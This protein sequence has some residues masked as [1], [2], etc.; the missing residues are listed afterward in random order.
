M[1]ANHDKRKSNR[2]LY[3]HTLLQLYLYPHCDN[4]NSP[5]PPPPQVQMRSFVR[6]HSKSQ[7]IAF[8][9]GH[10]HQHCSLLSLALQHSTL[11]CSLLS[12][13]LQHSTLLCSLCLLALLARFIHR[14]AHSLH[15][16]LTRCPMRCYKHWERTN[17][18]K[19][20]EFCPFVVQDNNLS[21]RNITGSDV[22][23][24]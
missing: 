9:T 22:V 14:L 2:F 20:R 23:E 10:L 4:N 12:L 17:R 5:P 3:K 15:S 6:A 21:Q 24:Q 19:D 11:L 16:G 7:I 18:W 13:A 8:S 1:A